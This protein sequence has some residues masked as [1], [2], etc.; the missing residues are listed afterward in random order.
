MTDDYQVCLALARSVHAGLSKI[1][2][3]SGV[4]QSDSQS[5][6]ERL[7]LVGL[8][9]RSRDIDE[10]YRLV[11]PAFWA[12]RSVIHRLHTRPAETTVPGLR[13]IGGFAGL[14]QLLDVWRCTRAQASSPTSLDTFSTMV[15][16]ILIKARHDVTLLHTYPIADTAGFLHHT[17]EYLSCRG[18]SIRVVR[19]ARFMSAPEWT[20]Y[21][22]TLAERNIPVLT[23]AELPGRGVVIDGGRL[24]LVHEGE[25][26]TRIYTDH[27]PFGPEISVGEF[28]QFPQ[29][30]LLVILNQLCSGASVGRVAESL[31]M[32]NRTVLRAR[33][34]LR[35]TFNAHDTPG[36]VFNAA[37]LGLIDP[38]PTA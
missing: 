6:V 36:L 16:E 21:S 10:A 32:A 30:P 2:A 17:L 15:E 33:D 27:S 20:P 14:Q 22:Q 13:E 23:A 8:V 18:I 11:H 31:G 4:T 37:A 7:R 3:E 12:A 25:H 26:T 1:V 9:R 35:A 34:R 38:P 24:A 19:D 28:A 29:P 5:A